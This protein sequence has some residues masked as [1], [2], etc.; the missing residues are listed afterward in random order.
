[1]RQCLCFAMLL[2]MG[3]PSSRLWAEP[4]YFAL[5][6]DGKKMGYAVET[7][8]VEGNKVTTKQTM[9]MTITRMGMPI[10]MEATETAFETTDGKPLG[11]ELE[12][13]MSLMTMKVS[14][15]INDQGMMEIVSQALGAEQKSVMPWPDGAVMSEGLRLLTK[16]MGLKEGT[17]Y[18]AKVF[19]SALKQAV[20]TEIEI[21]PRRQ[22][23]LLGRVVSL[24]EV[25]STLSTL[26]AGKVTSTGY[27]DDDLQQQKSEIPL[28]GIKVEMIACD[29]AFALAEVE[30]TTDLV[31]HM[32]IASPNAL[33]NLAQLK[34]V[35]YT[36]APT[37]GPRNSLRRGS[38]R[39]PLS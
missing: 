23:D 14:G 22:V 25:K 24:T 18:T 20:D 3:I 33:D 28:M 4:E 2:M 15:T 10:T 8:L 26:G 16:R 6:M 30:D 27:V 21:G 5:L 13:N 29:K 34:S 19:T 39:H 32:L 7:R 17:T 38:R 36:L 9:R 11:F 37:A 12:Q 35:T 31:S 1:M